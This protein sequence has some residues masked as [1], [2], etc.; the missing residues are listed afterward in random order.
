MPLPCGHKQRVMLDLRQR[1][2]C[3]TAQLGDLRF[4]LGHWQVD[5]PAAQLAVRV[6]KETLMFVSADYESDDKAVNDRP[7]DLQR[8][9]LLPDGAELPVIAERFK[10][11][12]ILFHPEVLGFFGNKEKLGIHDRILQ[13]VKGCEE[14]IQVGITA[15]PL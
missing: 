11:P 1:C 7:A 15:L 2:A 12:E 6:V 10:P 9:Y 5:N 4:A 3:M 14:A 13:A 8:E